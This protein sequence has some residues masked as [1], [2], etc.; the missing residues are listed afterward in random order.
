[1]KLGV[2][3]SIG[4]QSS[5]LVTQLWFM[6]LQEF[7]GLMVHSWVL[8]H[9]SHHLECSPGGP[10][11][12]DYI[13]STG[14]CH[15]LQEQKTTRIYQ[16]YHGKFNIS[17][18]NSYFILKVPYQKLE[19]PRTLLTILCFCLHKIF[20]LGEIFWWKMSNTLENNIKLVSQLPMITHDTNVHWLGII[21][22]PYMHICIYLPCVRTSRTGLCPLPL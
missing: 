17:M 14:P 16:E 18:Y 7:S 6:S 22:Y 5:T 10:N 15:G 19:Y 2:I 4:Y 1:M 21:T 8:G 9:I 13:T 3:Y 20:F 11:A 12:I